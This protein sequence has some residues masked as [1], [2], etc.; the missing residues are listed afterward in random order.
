MKSI[1]Y[2]KLFLMTLALGLVTTSCMDD[3]WKDP[4]GDTPAFGNNNLVETNV[5]T[6][7]KLKEMY[8]LTPATVNKHINDTMRIADGVQIKGVVTGH[9][10]EGNIYN[11]IAVDDGSAGIIICIAQG[12]LC[13][14]LQIGQEILIDLGGLYIGT[15]R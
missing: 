12:G 4:T 15:Y 13:G 8:D 1:K 10:V 7:A 2:L 6:I 3:D 11:E 14:Q 5:V 9:D